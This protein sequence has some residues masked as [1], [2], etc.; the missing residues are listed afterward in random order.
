MATIESGSGIRDSVPE[1][2]VY[3]DMCFSYYFRSPM[4][5]R[6]GSRGPF[7]AACALFFFLSFHI[8]MEHFTLLCGILFQKRRIP[9]SSIR[10][11]FV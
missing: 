4:D 8:A 1:L 3:C 7:M 2:C 9:L 10:R 11:I 6:A 5:S